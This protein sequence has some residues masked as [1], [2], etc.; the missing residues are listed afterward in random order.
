MTSRRT[1]HASISTLVICLLLGGVAAAADRD[2]DGY[3]R[4]MQGPMVGA[5][6]PTTAMIWLRTRA[7]TNS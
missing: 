4:L 5:V 1:L 7:F 6:S 2:D 3:P